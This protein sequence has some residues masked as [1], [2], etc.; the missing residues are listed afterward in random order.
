[1]GG[2]Q[3]G[4]GFFKMPSWGARAA[5][6]MGWK[7]AKWAGPRRALGVLTA[8]GP[9]GRTARWGV[10]KAAASTGRR[11]GRKIVKYGA[12]LAAG[13]L[14]LSLLAGLLR[15]SSK[16]Q[17]QQSQQQKGGMRNPFGR[18]RP[19]RWQRAK[20]YGGLA[21]GLVAPVLAQMAVE[22]VVDKMTAPKNESSQTGG[23]NRPRWTHFD[24][25]D[26]RLHG[27]LAKQ[28]MFRK[29]DRGPLG[30]AARWYRRENLRRHDSLRRKRREA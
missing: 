26:S 12:P 8:R 4:R 10:K 17:R 16:P 5:A 18:R 21:A 23:V 6:G 19:T 24:I 15:P 7:A 13:G 9:V 14:G 20:S 1:M 25:L 30:D 3:R 11:A 28:A 2:V 29:D 22:R 27:K